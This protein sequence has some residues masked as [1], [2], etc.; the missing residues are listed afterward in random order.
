MN[1]SFFFGYGSLVNCNTHEFPE[2]HKATAH[3]WR[4]VWRG[5]SLRPV[6]FLTVIPDDTSRIQGLIAGVP[7]ESWKALDE[8]ERAY[9]RVH[10]SDHVQH[11]LPDRPDIAIYAIPKGRHHAPSKDHP[12][13]QSYVDVVLQGYLNEFGTDGVAQFI[14]TTEGWASP[15]MQD[16]A[17][18][19]YPRHQTLNRAERQMVD[20]A[21]DQAGATRI[22]LNRAVLGSS[23]A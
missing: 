21:L 8:R 6:A 3:G 14:A 9:E 15:V 18:P 13:L 17:D 4:R 10:V 1:E 20:D 19:I 23:P 7:G 5:T 16:R 12:I 2:T 22:P 11:S